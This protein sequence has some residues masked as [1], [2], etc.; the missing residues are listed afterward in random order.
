METD[1]GID[2]L[3]GAR[4]AM[5][6]EQ[7]RNRGVGDE[8]V[9]TAMA[10]V[11]RHR[12][13]ADEHRER[14]YEDHPI[15]IGEGQTISQPYIV[16][17]MLEVLRLEPQD[18]VLEVGTG[19]GYLTAL[20]AELVASVYSIERIPVLAARADALLRQLGYNN[21]K[22]VVGD[23]GQGLPGSVPFDS[24]VVS[25]AAPQLPDPLFAQLREG[26]RMIITVGPAH[27]Q[28]LQ[29][30][31]KIDGQPLVTALEGCRFV[32]LIGEEGYR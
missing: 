16:A 28:E 31:R 14:A 5:V 8:R 11:P 7:L 10:T 27:V 4:Q 18:N 15:P 24:I 22:I 12:F 26:G 20:L 9:L 29:L 2:A 19:S 23:G 1:T 6:R 13:V 21:V 17:R 3:A 30:V 32:P 25:A